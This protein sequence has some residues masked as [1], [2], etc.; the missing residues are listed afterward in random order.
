MYIF[1]HTYKILHHRDHMVEFN[2]M[3]G[4]TANIVRLLPV[5]SVKCFLKAE[6]CFL[7]AVIQGERTNN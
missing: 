7:S 3:F 1:D 5:H 2:P 4:H 6:I